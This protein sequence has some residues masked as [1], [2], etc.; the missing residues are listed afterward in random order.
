MTKK[1]ISMLLAFT[2]VASIL[3]GCGG[4]D[5]GAAADTGTDTNSESSSSG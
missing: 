4:K 1:V 3:A 5:T 2:M